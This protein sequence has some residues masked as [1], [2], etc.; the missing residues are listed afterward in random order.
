MEVGD[1]Q[2]IS[3]AE[4]CSQ[5]RKFVLKKKKQILLLDFSFMECFRIFA[6]ASN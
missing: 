1:G 3:T 5:V 4:G 6:G 2:C